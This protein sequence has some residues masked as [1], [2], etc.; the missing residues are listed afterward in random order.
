[1]LNGL[2]ACATNMSDAPDELSWE[3]ICASDMAQPIT[4]NAG[5]TI[6]TRQQIDIHNAGYE[7]SCLNNCP[8]EE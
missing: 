7:C 6:P 4:W 3:A 2:A 8:P 5:D 1:M